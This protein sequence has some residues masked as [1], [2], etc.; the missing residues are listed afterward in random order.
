MF[1]GGVLTGERAW[2]RRQ[3][4][5]DGRLGPAALLILYALWLKLTLGQGQ[6]L[7]LDEAWTAAIV[8]HPA[9]SDAARQTYLD[10]N[11]PL[12]YFLMWG[13]QT[14]FGLSNAALRAPSLI[15]AAL[16]PILAFGLP[17]SL[18][19]DSRLAW[20]ALLS[21]WAPGL[22][23]AQEAR[24]YALL[25]ALSTAQTAI[26]LEL[27]RAP[28]RKL[29][30]AWACVALLACLTHYDAGF[31]VLAQAGALG[32]KLRLRLLRLWPAAL[33]FAPGALWLAVHLPRL[34]EFARPEVAWYDRL[35]V[36]GVAEAVSYEFG[37]HLALF[38][39]IVCVAGAILLALSARRGA[40]EGE[41][42]RLDL[43][44]DAL[45]A[46]APSVVGFALLLAL[47]V[48]H[49]SYTLRYGTPFAPGILL[50]TLLLIRVAGA[51]WSWLVTTLL[52]VGFALVLKPGRLREAFEGRSIF[53]YEAASDFI[54]EVAPRRL[55][56]TWDHPA[57]AVLRPEQLDV[58]GGVFLRRAGHPVQVDPVRFA[59]GEEPSQR[60]LTAAAAPRSAILW[61]YDTSVH[62]TFAARS[63]PQLQSDARWECRNFGES[64][65]GVLACRERA[66][67]SGDGR[68][69]A[70]RPA[71]LAKAP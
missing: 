50:G 48:L 24:C 69:P 4:R 1:S 26:Y 6:P 35:D 10:V 3:L 54:A 61:L 44:S 30:I 60:L 34:V 46:C 17:R 68:W 66:A 37:A 63:P 65:I 67:A 29:A 8:G 42:R 62:N 33:V 31:L 47:G 39:A 52:L 49:R 71:I 32:I 7:W 15:A 43:D 9:L 11:A 59:A 57:S 55:V 22:L 12:Y 20:A 70:P 41:A 58:A 27:W 18:G 56:F 21:L 14:L 2:A 25:L 64:N 40:A 38:S 36:G 16:L 13:W 45:A 19:R 51:R 28:G 5:L 23:M 53:S